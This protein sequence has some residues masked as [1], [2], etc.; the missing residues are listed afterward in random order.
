MT[1]DGRRLLSGCCQGRIR[2]SGPVARRR[3]HGLGFEGEVVEPTSGLEPLT[4]S[5][6]DTDDAEE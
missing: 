5:L 4:C 3:S 2:A 6:R 1:F